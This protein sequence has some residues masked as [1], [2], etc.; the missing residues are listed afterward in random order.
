MS[1]IIR[2]S[3]RLVCRHAAYSFPICVVDEKIVEMA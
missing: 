2:D 3:D 1:I